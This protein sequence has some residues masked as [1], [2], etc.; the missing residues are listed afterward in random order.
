MTPAQ[1]D[2]N[3]AERKQLLEQVLA[4]GIDNPDWDD[5]AIAPEIL[6]E[7]AAGLAF[8]PRPVTAAG[9]EITERYD[10]GPRGAFMLSLIGNGVRFPKDLAT[11]LH[12]GRS[13]VTAELNRL[14]SAGLVEITAGQDRRQSRLALTPAGRD[15][16]TTVRRTL[17]RTIEIALARYSADEITLFAAM[18]RAFQRI[19]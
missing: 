12:I 17:S 8:G 9:T 11:V 4:H 16:A 15:A 14:R 3:E 13:L 18:L 19:D 5:G 2:E 6:G 7:I 1:E 10:L